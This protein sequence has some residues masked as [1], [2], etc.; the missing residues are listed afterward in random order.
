MAA[1]VAVI[2][3]GYALAALA[4]ALMARILPTTRADAATAG[5]I[6]SFA[7]YAAILLWAFAARGAL[8]LWLWLGGVGLLVGLLLAWS[9]LA[10]AGR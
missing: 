2:P 6:V 1:R 7:I 3:Y 10:G 8:R 9:L 4:S 5:M